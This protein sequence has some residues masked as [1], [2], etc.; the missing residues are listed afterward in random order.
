MLCMIQIIAD[1]LNFHVRLQGFKWPRLPS[2]HPCLDAA[3]EVLR[4]G[5]SLRYEFCI[6]LGKKK[7]VEGNLDLSPKIQ[8]SRIDSCLGSGERGLCRPLTGLTHARPLYRLAYCHSALEECDI[9][10]SLSSSARS[11]RSGNGWIGIGRSSRL[12]PFPLID[13][14]GRFLQ[15]GIVCECGE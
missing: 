14:S 7:L 8:S 9:P 5:K 12:K 1:L 13:E 6:A 11:H 4:D 15:T 3:Q 10:E 2:I